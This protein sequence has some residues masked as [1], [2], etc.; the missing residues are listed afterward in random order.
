MARHCNHVLPLL[1]PS[2]ATPLFPS[3]Q[4]PA[5][6]APSSCST[7]TL[8]CCCL[9]CPPPI[10]RC[11]CIAKGRCSNGCD[12]CGPVWGAPVAIARPCAK[13]PF[14]C[15]LAHV[16]PA[17]VHG[18]QGTDAPM[19]T[20]MS[21]DS[22]ATSTCAVQHQPVCACNWRIVVLSGPREDH[23]QQQSGQGKGH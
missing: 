11:V 12:G 13:L 4:L 18:R 14:S 3:P 23:A 10:I 2:C 8:H 20:T 5:P 7:T 19:T 15:C 16:T 1:P 22:R 17:T 21:R 6:A 9:G